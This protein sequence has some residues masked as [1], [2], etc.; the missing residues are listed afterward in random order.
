MCENILS[1]YKE[2]RSE[3]SVDLTADDECVLYVNF[4]KEVLNGRWKKA[5][6]FLLANKNGK[7]ILRY[8]IEVIKG[9]WKEAE[10]HGKKVFGNYIYNYVK[11]Y[12]GNHF[13]E[14]EI[15]NSP[16]MYYFWYQ[17]MLNKILK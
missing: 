17:M 9:R 11:H 12:F 4:C 16:L 14:E 5:E 13:P 1:K 15:G 10:Y 6:N 3:I 8:S 7:Q 2:W